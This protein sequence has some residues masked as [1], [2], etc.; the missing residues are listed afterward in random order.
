MRFLQSDL[1]QDD[2][3]SIIHMVDVDALQSII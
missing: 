3:I 1:Y 2:S